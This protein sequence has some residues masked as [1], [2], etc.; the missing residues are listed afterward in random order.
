MEESEVILIDGDE[1]RWR[2]K[3]H[4]ELAWRVFE[5]LSGTISNRLSGARVRL[6]TL[7]YEQRKENVSRK[8]AKD[9]APSFVAPS[10]TA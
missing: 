3:R 5:N 1:L 10:G 4:P 7:E 2:M 9:T 8:I 6:I